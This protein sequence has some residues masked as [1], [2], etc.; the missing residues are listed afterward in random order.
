MTISMHQVCVPVFV[1]GL[2]GLVGVLD[3][4]AAHA[5]ERKIA[6]ATEVALNL[7]GEIHERDAR[8]AGFEREAA[9]AQA[10]IAAV[11]GENA[12]LTSELQ[13]RDEELRKAAADGAR[14]AEEARLA[15]LEI[16]ALEKRIEARHEDLA[17][18]GQLLMSRERDLATAKE[19]LDRANCRLESQQQSAATAMLALEARLVNVTQS[20]TW[21]LMAPVRRLSSKLRPSAGRGDQLSRD[22]D[23]LRKSDMFDETWYLQ[24]YPDVAN[25]NLGAVEHYLQFGAT[26]RRNPGP[27]FDTDAYLKNNPDV[28]DSGLNPLVHYITHGKIE[29]RHP[30]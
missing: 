5:A 14:S 30:K 7:K 23:A 18:L 11:R 1:Q 15:G 19:E 13:D 6:A 8:L 20:R 25:S 17:K 27:G 16:L 29:G 12:K 21:R 26:E 10:S 24:T 22:R 3:K 4:A 28:S 2:T 9:S